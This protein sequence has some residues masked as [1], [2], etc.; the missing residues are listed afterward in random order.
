MRAEIKGGELLAEMAERKE[1]QKAGDN[2]RGSSKPRLPPKLS[3][4]GISRGK[5]NVLRF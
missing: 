3:D 4:L 5:R 1:R 2:Q